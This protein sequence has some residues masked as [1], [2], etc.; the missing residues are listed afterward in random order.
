MNVIQ[1]GILELAIWEGKYSA[2]A[3]NYNTRQEGTRALREK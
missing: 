1:D 3:N 2:S